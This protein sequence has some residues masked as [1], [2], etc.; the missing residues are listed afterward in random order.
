MATDPKLKRKAKLMAEKGMSLSDIAAV[1][2]VPL[3]TLKHWSV[4]DKWEKGKLV[5][6]LHQKE[7]ET[8]IKAAERA[9]LTR[10]L[11]AEVAVKLL[12]AR[13]VLM[14]GPMG[15]TRFPMPEGKPTRIDEQGN[16]SVAVLGVDFEII[17]DRRAMKDGASLGA[18]ILGMK[19]AD[20]ESEK[21]NDNLLTLIR[22]MRPK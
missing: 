18:D 4:N 15:V 14:R 11:V 20:I 17:D 16:K 9:G 21:T 2:P 8:A 19:K 1:L 10:A 7:Q 3:R 22:S 5:P 13:D 6:L 12:N